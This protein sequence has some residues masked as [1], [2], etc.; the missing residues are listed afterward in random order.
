[1]NE[2]VTPV[3]AFQKGLTKKGNPFYTVNLADGRQAT[4]FDNKILESLNK[5]IEVEVKQSEYNGQVEYI[6]NF[7]GSQGG[8]R[9]G[10]NLDYNQKKTA[11]ECAVKSG[12][13]EDDQ[14]I[15]TR[16]GVFLAWLKQ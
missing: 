9:S 3:N 7:P 10:F 4:C 6:I 14:T 2:K 11:L 5:E 13:L 12:A 15:I 8:G 1:M 16:A